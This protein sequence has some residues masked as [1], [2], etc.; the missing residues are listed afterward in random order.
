MAVLKKENASLKSQCD[1][2]KTECESLRKKRDTGNDS[3]SSVPTQLH[4]MKQDIDQQLK[5]RHQQWQK[6][7]DSLHDKLKAFDAMV[8][9]NDQMLLAKDEQIA[10]LHADLKHTTAKLAQAKDDLYETKR[11]PIMYTPEEFQAVTQTPKHVPPSDLPSTSAHVN[12]QP[13]PPGMDSPQQI[14]SAQSVVLQPSPPVMDT[15]TC[16]SSLPVNHD[17]HRSK[18]YASAT[19]TTAHDS[20]HSSP[21]NSARHGQQ[22]SPR[23]GNHRRQDHQSSPRA[24][25]RRRPK[26]SVVIIGNSHMS[27]LDTSRFIP[28]AEVTSIRAYTIDE[29]NNQLNQLNF[30]PDCV[31]IHEITNDITACPPDKCA[32]YLQSIV[33]YHGTRF[34]HTKFVISLGVPR[35]DNLF[36]NTMTDVT[37]AFIKCSVLKS[38]NNNMSFC[39]NSN[40]VKN[41]TPLRH[42]LS[43]SDWYHLSEEGSCLLYSNIRCKVEQVLSLNRRGYFRK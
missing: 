12:P 33:D 14:V 43:A 21:T 8:K 9:R 1:S 2:L 38:S 27:S 5:N 22:S 34:S 30:V 26:P 39:D 28:G 35:L 17:N 36:Y 31:V 10:S 23:S 7:F 18:S 40:F 4:K 19:G 24:G 3:C 11:A 42:L 32:S 20:S 29:A 13:L 25:N 41:G 37:N 16:S 6:S 15:P